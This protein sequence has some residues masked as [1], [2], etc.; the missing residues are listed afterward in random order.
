LS[1]A[2][3]LSGVEK[4]QVANENRPIFKFQNE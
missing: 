4:K 3:I 2:E 1:L